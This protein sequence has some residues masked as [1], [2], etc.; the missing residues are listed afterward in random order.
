MNFNKKAI[1][2]LQQRLLKIACMNLGRLRK[3][4]TEEVYKIMQIN[5]WRRTMSLMHIRLIK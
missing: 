5:S 3:T 4:I 1:G 2:L